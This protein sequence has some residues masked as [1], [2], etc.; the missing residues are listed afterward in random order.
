MNRDRIFKLTAD[1][2]K[3]LEG[4]KFDEAGAAIGLLVGT[5]VAG[6]VGCEE[7]LKEGIQAI[8]KDAEEAAIKIHRMQN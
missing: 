3:L 2:G 6:F 5:F 1:M 4:Q 8:A 7:H